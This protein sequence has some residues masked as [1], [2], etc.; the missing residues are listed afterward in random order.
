MGQGRKRGEPRGGACMEREGT[1]GASGAGCSGRAAL[2]GRVA[3]G[4]PQE[5]RGV[6]GRTRGPALEVGKGLHPCEERRRPPSDHMVDEGAL[7]S[8]RVVGPEPRRAQR[9]DERELGFAQAEVQAAGRRSSQGMTFGSVCLSRDSVQSHGAVCAQL[10][11][12]RRRKGAQ[13]QAGTRGA[14]GQAGGGAAIPSGRAVEGGG[15]RSPGKTSPRRKGCVVGKGR[16]LGGASG[17]RA[18]G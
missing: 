12:R 2:G 8:G 1:Q 15:G 10:G 6:G 7:R 16:E 4:R 11:S 5:V 18:E 3:A 9:A 13:D 17:L 14:A